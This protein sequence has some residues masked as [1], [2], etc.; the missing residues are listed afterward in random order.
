[1][2]KGAFTLSYL[3]TSTQF[4]SEKETFERSRASYSI[5]PCV[6]A[7][8]GACTLCNLALVSESVIPHGHFLPGIMCNKKQM[9][10][11]FA[12]VPMKLEPLSC[13]TQNKT[14]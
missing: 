4:D 1:M 7:C 5:H 10:S 14:N 6:I 2:K 11:N 8:V 13:Y 12:G 9:A 3:M